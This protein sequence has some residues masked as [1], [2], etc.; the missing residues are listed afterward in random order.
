[1]LSSVDSKSIM[2]GIKWQFR[3]RYAGK[4]FCEYFVSYIK[5][6]YIKMTVNL[7]M[8]DEKENWVQLEKEI[9]I[10]SRQTDN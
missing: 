9:H 8:L 7:V 5:K 4:W 2:P 6:K 3:K 1:M 10:L